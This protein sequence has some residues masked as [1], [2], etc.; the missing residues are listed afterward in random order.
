[1]L[2]Q[3]QRKEIDLK[4]GISPAYVMELTVTRL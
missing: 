2:D 3:G 1:M 4:Q